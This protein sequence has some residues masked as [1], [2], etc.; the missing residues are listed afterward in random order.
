MKKYVTLALILF[1]CL[2]L[3]LP[4]VHAE[5]GEENQEE[6]GT[7]EERVEIDKSRFQ[8][9]W[10]LKTSVQK[11]L[12]QVGSFTSPWWSETGAKARPSTSTRS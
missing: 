1:L 10:L 9:S 2:N 12:W 11:R 6:N 8:P 4:A 7:E 3:W 5:G